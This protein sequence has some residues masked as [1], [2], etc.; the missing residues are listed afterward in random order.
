MP[1]FSG[2]GL[3]VD[4]STMSWTWTLQGLYELREDGFILSDSSFFHGLLFLVYG[5][6]TYLLSMHI[7]SHPDWKPPAI[8]DTIKKLHN[9]ALSAVSLV[10]GI[11]MIRETYLDG[12]YTSWEN[13]A[14]RSTPNEGLYGL[15]NFIYLLSK[16]WEW[17]DT[18]FLS[19]YG[20]QI[21]PLHFFHHM[22]TF[23]MAALTHNFPVGGFA[24]INC[25]VHFVMYAHYAYPVRWARQFITSFQ[26]LQFV[27][28]ITVHTYGYLKGCFDFSHLGIEWWYCEGVV[29]GYFLLFVRFY[30]DNYIKPV[31]TKRAK[32]D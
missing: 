30:I 24:W 6:S 16:I 7:E 18:Y 10:M 5:V 19:L 17:G 3:D 1:K 25:L 26:L 13:M 4:T 14:C 29:I 15:A 21:I 9:V 23:T 27:T 20:K 12:R 8:L 32:K 31:W 22:T 28:V 11:V 2:F